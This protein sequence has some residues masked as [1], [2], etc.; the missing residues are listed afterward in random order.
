[1]AFNLVRYSQQDPQWKS[2]L[3]GGGPDTI[4]YIGCALTSLAMYSS[5]W[6]FTE[7]PATL[8]L[9]LNSAG[10]FVDEAIVW[11]TIT[12][13]HPQIKCTGLK[14]CMDTDAP[15]A[16][17]DASL[18]AGQP[19]IV[20]VDYSPDAGLQTHWVLLYA[21]EGNDY[22]IQD[23]WPSPPEAQPVT[24]LSRFSQGKP[25]QRS[26][27]AVAFYQCSAGAPVPP[28]TPPTPS[29]PPAPATPP[30]P[31][32]APVTTDLVLDVLPTATAGIKLHTAASSDSIAN[33][34]EMPGMPLNVIED[35]AGALAKLGKTDQWIYVR[36]PNGHQGYVA[37]W[38]V[39]ISSVPTP[40]PGPVPASTPP[41]PTAPPAPT[42]APPASGPQRMQV[43][44]V[45]TVG[46]AGLSVRAQPS[47]G[48]EKVNIEN[49]GARLTVIEPPSTALPKIGQLG[50][51][52]AV[53]ATNNQRGYVMAQYVQLKQ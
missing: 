38:Y 4:G 25:L 10:G 30:T 19:V 31:P 51:W 2:N 29:T 27:K 3:I 40:A 32:P 46:K 52:L 15:L 49:G 1:M 18:A 26:I 17:I 41:G 20:E 8:N 39:E 53:K 11:Q 9:K 35:K 43:V 6:G 37:A 23:P 45:Q 22:L 33:Y 34:A 12:K 7:T 42:S 48:A 50:Q 36:D 47:L 28:I 44:V 5:S 24:I 13:F 16:D 21:K 14:L